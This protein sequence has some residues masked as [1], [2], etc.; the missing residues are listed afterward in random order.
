MNGSVDGVSG[1]SPPPLLTAALE[2]AVLCPILL[3][4]VF[5]NICVCL[6]VAYVCSLKRR[7]SALILASLAVSDLASLSFVLFRLVWLYNTEA[8]CAKCQYFSVLQG[9]LMYIS[10]I[11]IFLLSCDR[12]VAIVHSMRYTEVVTKVKVGRALLVAWGLSLVSA[13]LIPW[14]FPIK[15]RSA[16]LAAMVGCGEVPSERSQIYIFFAVF[17]FTFFVSIP[18]LVMIF[19]YCRI[20]KIAWSQNSRFWPGENLNPELAELTRKRKKEMKWVKTISKYALN[21]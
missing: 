13:I 21:F 8:A 3:V 4:N 7:P 5:G 10:S 12:Y 16:F 19:I 14:I 17:N 11:H 20:A 9:T 1:A 2:T 6:A 18:F 15:G